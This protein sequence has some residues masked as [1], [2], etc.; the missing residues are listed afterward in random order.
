MLDV[1]YDIICAIVGH[2]QGSTDALRSCS[3][4][5]RDWCTASRGSLFDTA[6]I[7]HP[8]NPLYPSEITVFTRHI[9][10]SSTQF[11]RHIRHLRLV[12]SESRNEQDPVGRRFEGSPVSVEELHSILPLLSSL[13]SLVLWNARLVGGPVTLSSHSY[14]RLQL[15]QLEVQAVVH[16][17]GDTI[18]ALLSLLAA[19][20]SIHVLNLWF[21]QWGRRQPLGILAPTPNELQHTD[22]VRIDVLVLRHLITPW[23]SAL[24]NA[25]KRMQP[26]GHSL[27][28]VGIYPNGARAHECVGIDDYLRLEQPECVQIRLGLNFKGPRYRHDVC[29]SNYI[30]YTATGHAWSVLGL[31]D[32]SA[33]K[34][35]VIS[36]ECEAH[37]G[38]T[39]QFLFRSVLKACAGTLAPDAV[40]PK[41]ETLVLQVSQHS[42][43]DPPFNP[44][45]A[46]EAIDTSLSSLDSLRAV[47]IDFAYGSYCDPLA[48]ERLL[49]MTHGRGLLSTR[50]N[51]VSS[52][53]ILVSIAI[54]PEVVSQSDRGSLVRH[55]LLTRS[56][57]CALRIMESRYF[58]DME[59]A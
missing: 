49:P 52:C 32:Q 47:V 8:P 29:I 51:T 20:S 54:V 13:R 35:L 28:S 53:L 30:F 58:G 55:H 34:T 3:L 6:A 41:L 36:L 56:N 31:K 59:I 43:D 16:R 37:E 24:Q 15:D 14:K 23:A 10:T 39:R 44:E 40:P 33:V 7:V 45:S 19:F 26:P 21:E 12:G 2:L 4:V 46:W 22:H 50:I 1:P 42:R 57:H 11:G 9:T 5:S 48:F 38:G 25:V 18:T 17:A 27:Q